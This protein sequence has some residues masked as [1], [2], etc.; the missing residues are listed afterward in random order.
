MKFSFYDADGT[1][2]RVLVSGI[3]ICSLDQY[4][5]LNSYNYSYALHKFTTNKPET[6]LVVRYHFTSYLI[7][8]SLAVSLLLTVC[9]STL[10][11]LTLQTVLLQLLTLNCI[12]YASI[13]VCFGPFLSGV[14]LDLLALICS[15]LL[16]ALNC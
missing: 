3:L 11:C 13:S 12:S 15:A 7:V 8:S 9:L 2:C 4:L 1:D 6:C 10:D 5:D 16:L 14:F